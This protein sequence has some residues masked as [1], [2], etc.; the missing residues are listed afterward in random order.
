MSHR[1]IEWL[2]DRRIIYR[3]DPVNDVP[4]ISTKHYNYYEDGVGV[5]FFFLWVWMGM[6]FTL[7]LKIDLQDIDDERSRSF[8]F[9]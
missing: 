1:K 5:F 9:H 4:T 6:F 8:W 7:L 2:N 3:K